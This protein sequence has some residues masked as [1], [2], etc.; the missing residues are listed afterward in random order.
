VHVATA[1]HASLNKP[2]DYGYGW[3]RT[4]YGEVDAYYQSG[5]GGQIAMA[6]PALDLVIAIQA[7]NYNAFGIWKHELDELIPRII[8]SCSR[9]TATRRP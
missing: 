8:A 1:A 6:I 2:D 3:W 7:G 4:T 5:N 9:P